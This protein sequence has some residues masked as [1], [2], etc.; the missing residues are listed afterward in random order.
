MNESQIVFSIYFTF[1]SLTIAP[2]DNSKGIQAYERA[3]Q[4]LQRWASKK[5]EVKGTSSQTLDMLVLPCIY[6]WRW[7]MGDGRWAMGDGR[8]A[9]GDGRWAM[10]VGG[11]RITFKSFTKSTRGVRNLAAMC[12]ARAW[13]SEKTGSKLKKCKI[14]QGGKIFR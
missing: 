8:W 9:M 14:K 11:R 2:A 13:G 6:S 12:K 1:A 3:I 7:A 4:T 10:G 5:G